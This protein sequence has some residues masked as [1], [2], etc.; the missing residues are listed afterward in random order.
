MLI[1]NVDNNN[2]WLFGYG[3]TNYVKE[4]KA[5]GLD[6]K[7]RIQEFYQDCFF[8]LENGIDWKKRLGFPNQKDL[9]DV[10]INR[11][12]SSVDGVFSI[13]DFTSEVIGRKY[14]C[15]FKV[16]HQYMAQELEFQFNSEDLWQTH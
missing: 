8:A 10:D 2:D 5:I 15:R 14:Q 3:K 6:I 16:Y 1:R 7:L 4:E 12:A 9:L 11:I 13:Y